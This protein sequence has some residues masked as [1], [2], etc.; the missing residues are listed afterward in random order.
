MCVKMGLLESFP[1]LLPSFPSLTT[2]ANDGKLSEAGNGGVGQK[3]SELL[4]CC[5][6]T[7]VAK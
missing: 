1:W 7:R 3:H 4:A 2:T 6:A 5:L